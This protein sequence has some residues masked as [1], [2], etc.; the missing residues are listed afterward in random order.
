MTTIDRTTSPA[1]TASRR[2]GDIRKNCKPVG[3][4]TWA[5]LRPAAMAAPAI[6][7]TTV[8]RRPSISDSSRNIHSTSRRCMPIARSVPIS[9]VRSRMAIHM[10]FMMPMTMM[11]IRMAIRTVDS[12]CSA[13]SVQLM[14]EI[15]SSQLVTSSFCPVQSSRETDWNF[16]QNARG[17]GSITR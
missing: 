13:V 6:T 11:A 1:C 9:R 15:S 14:N 2:C 5:A 12:T 17:S 4:G 3:T 16:I 8:D 7:P 10:V